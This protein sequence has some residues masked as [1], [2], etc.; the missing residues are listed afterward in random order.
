M[1]NFKSLTAEELLKWQHSDLEN[2]ECRAIVKA[3]F[4][5]LEELA[6]IKETKQHQLDLFVER[7]Q[8]YEELLDDSDSYIPELSRQIQRDITLLTFP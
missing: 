1:I 7:L 6:D 4:L 5:R 3:L 2:V 8:E